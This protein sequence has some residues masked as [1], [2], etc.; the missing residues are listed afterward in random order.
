VVF[1]HDADLPIAILEP[2]G[3]RLRARPAEVEA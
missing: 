1:E 2:D 3:G